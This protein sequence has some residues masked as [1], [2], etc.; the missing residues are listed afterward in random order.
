MHVPE[1]LAAPPAA[2]EVELRAH[3]R[4]GVAVAPCRQLSSDFGLSPT[5]RLEL[6]DVHLLDSTAG[7]DTFGAR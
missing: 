3:G 1:R 7:V 2:E 6:Q 5:H 4:H